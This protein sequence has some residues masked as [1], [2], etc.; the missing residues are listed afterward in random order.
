MMIWL[1][2]TNH[3]WGQCCPPDELINKHHQVSRQA[4]R[5]IVGL[6]HQFLSWWISLPWN[7][8]TTGMDPYSY[9]LGLSNWCRCN[10]KQRGSLVQPRLLLEWPKW[11]WVVTGQSTTSRYQT[12]K[13]SACWNWADLLLA[14]TWPLV[15]GIGHGWRGGWAP[16]DPVAESGGSPGTHGFLFSPSSSSSPP[17]EAYH[18]GV[19]INDMSPEG[20]Q[21]PPTMLRPVH[22]PIYTQK[23]RILLTNAHHL[24]LIIFS[25]SS[26]QAKLILSISEPWYH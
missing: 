4:A 21:S 11:I 12:T 18:L 14:T 25:I 1:Y 19:S 3:F 10:L 23:R 13:S 2:L 15:E 22:G 6:T 9:G 17:E 24:W 5:P 7:G 26:W 8:T 20:T 16:T